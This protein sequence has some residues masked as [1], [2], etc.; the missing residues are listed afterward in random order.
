V[1]AALDVDPDD[2]VGD[3]DGDRALVSDPQ[4]DPVD[5]DDGIDLGGF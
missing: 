5:V 3:L 4:P 2:Q 1:L